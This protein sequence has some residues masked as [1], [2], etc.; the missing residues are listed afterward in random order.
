MKGCSLIPAKTSL[1]ESAQK[2]SESVSGLQ[3]TIEEAEVNEKYL[4]KRAAE[5][6]ITGHGRDFNKYNWSS[7]SLSTQDMW[8]FYQYK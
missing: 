4:S 6:Y 1:H 2:L 8:A 7:A 3:T 5:I